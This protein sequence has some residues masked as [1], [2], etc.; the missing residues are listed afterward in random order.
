MSEPLSPPPPP[1]TPPPPAGPVAT[2]QVQGPALGLMITGVIGI[3]FAILGLL[4]NLLGFGM[5][6]L[7]DL[8]G[9]YGSQYWTM[10]SGGVGILS[11][12]I[13]LAA[14]GF[15][16]WAAMKMKVLEQWTAAVVASIVAMIPC[17]CPTCIIGIPIGIW[18]LVVLLKP[19][20]KAAFKG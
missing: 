11:A 14:W 19:E 16:I 10:L 15:V 4:M 7:Q 13:A 20:V 18:A 6:G 5:A 17:F 9:D 2:Q 12:V 1:Y 3:L 8:G